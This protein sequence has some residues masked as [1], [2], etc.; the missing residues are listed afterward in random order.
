MPYANVKSSVILN[1]EFFR[2]EA[3]K[4]NANPTDRKQ[5]LQKQQ[6]NLQAAL[7]RYATAMQDL[8]ER[9]AKLDGVSTAGQWMTGIGGVAMAIPTIY[10]QIG[11][12]VVSLAGMIVN[13]AEKKKDSKALRELQ[14]E[15]RQIQL[16]VTQIKT[17]YDNY[18][19]EL[20]RMNL[21][22]IA[23]FGAAAFLLTKQ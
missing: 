13:A 17:Y 20:S 21:L 4:Y 14:A 8:M 16:E 19:G 9:G 1:P 2:L 18:T 23:L 10:S 6:I 7:N 5:W 15:A 22:P 12:A 11:G 3:L